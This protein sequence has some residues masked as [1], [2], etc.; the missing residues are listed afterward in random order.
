MVMAH[1]P[2]ALQDCDLLLVLEGGRQAAFG[3]R[4]EVLR[5]RVRNPAQILRG[6]PV[7]GAA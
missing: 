5:T 4:D 3:P 2:A 1:R 6:V 7:G